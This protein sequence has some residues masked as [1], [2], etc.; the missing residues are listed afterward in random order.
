MVDE[1]GKLD[2]LDKQILKLLVEDYHCRLLAKTLKQPQS[3]IQYRLKRLQKN[4]LIIDSPGV[5]NTK[6]YRLTSRSS[7]LLIHN[8]SHPSLMPFTAH[9][10][11]F[12]FPILEGNQP[13]SHSKQKMKNWESYIF[14][15]STYTIKT[16]TKHIIVFIN[17]DLGADSIDNLNLKYSEL[18]QTYASKFAKEHNITIGGISRYREGHFTIKDSALGQIISERGEF[19]TQSGIMID[20]S[21]SSG[22]LEMLEDSARSFEFAFNI[23]PALTAGLHGEMRG[24][25]VKLEA[26]SSTLADIQVRLQL[27]AEN[28]PMISHMKKA[29]ETLSM[30]AEEMQSQLLQQE[31][32]SNL[33]KACV[34]IMYG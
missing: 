2:E 8:E 18:A 4:G 28:S 5:Y 33:T 12:K 1:V 32:K 3:T 9:C 21:R 24:V 19:R 17:Q 30:Q 16:T 34:N 27:D 14:S 6:L 23:L 13:K 22:D 29:V 31:E 11:S 10:M 20:K 7:E 15:F 25:S 26:L